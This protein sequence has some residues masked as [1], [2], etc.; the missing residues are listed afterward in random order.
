[1]EGKFWFCI[2][3]GTGMLAVEELPPF[4]LAPGGGLF[5][6]LVSN[7]KDHTSL[8]CVLSAPTSSFRTWG[9]T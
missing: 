3:G 9:E 2:P 7:C 1:M 6:T 5:L 4:C 8:F